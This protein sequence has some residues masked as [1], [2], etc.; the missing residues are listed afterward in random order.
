MSAVTK[1][2][3][4]RHARVPGFATR[5]Y[6]HRQIEADVSHSEPFEILARRLPKDAIWFTS[7]MRRAQQ[8]AQAIVDAGYPKTE[9]AIAPELA[10]QDFG[11]WQGRGFNE[12][13]Q[14]VAGGNMIEFWDKGLAH[15]PPNGESYLDLM[16]RTASIVEKLRSSHRGNTL[17]LVSH[18]GTIRAALAQA[19]DLPAKA[20]ASFAIE[21]LSTTRID[22][23]D[24]DHARPG[25]WRV[26]FVNA[27][28]KI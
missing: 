20:A 15:R 8:T 25:G 16:A 14:D 11:D 4:V 21:N 12:I 7:D 3:W 28:A 6:D 10:E 17:I 23:I 22:A 2:Y 9:I 26:A 27:R 13:L 5:L 18:G 19:L 1:F 24:G